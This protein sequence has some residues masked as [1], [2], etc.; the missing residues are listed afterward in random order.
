MEHP[1]IEIVR[2]YFDG[3]NGADGLL[4][5]TLHPDVVHYFLP[6][7][8]PPV[9]GA[10]ALAGYWRA[11]REGLNARWTIDHIVAAVDEVVSE[12]TI[13]LTWP[14]TERR[15]VF[16]GTEWYVFLDGRIAEV[17]AYYGQD[18]ERSCELQGFP[19]AERG[20]PVEAP[21]A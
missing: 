19:Y 12:W 18:A 20:Y 17:R 3:C 13:F 9:R 8:S 11:L 15:L 16:R 4:E 10:A 21:G 1:N 7:T 6:P 5:A 2:R 14:G